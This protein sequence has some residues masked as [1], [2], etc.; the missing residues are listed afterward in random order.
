MPAYGAGTDPGMATDLETR[1][2]MERASVPGS[3]RDSARAAAEAVVC[4]LALLVTAMGLLQRIYFVETEE[5]L[6]GAKVGTWLAGAALVAFLLGLGAG[7]ARRAEAPGWVRRTCLALA[8][9]LLGG[10]IMV[11]KALLD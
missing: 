8:V 4:V 6:Y 9:V 10:G 3:G 5:A 11:A 1:R 2:E 7:V